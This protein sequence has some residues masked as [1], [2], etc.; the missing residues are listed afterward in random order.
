MLNYPSIINVI[1]VEINLKGTQGMTQLIKA[2]MI[3]LALTF[4]ALD[5]KNGYDYYYYGNGGSNYK[6]LNK[7]SI[8]KIA[9]A[10]V[11]RLTMKKKIPK[12][13]KSMPV[14]QIHK[15]NT[16]DWI[17]TFNNVKIKNKS[18]QNLYIFVGIYGKIKGVNYIGH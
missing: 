11:K 1:K 2:V 17:V 7:T 14:S 3:L 10:E 12:S 5:A 4:T 18:K 8:T 9:K 15:S 16:D 13:W 6:Q